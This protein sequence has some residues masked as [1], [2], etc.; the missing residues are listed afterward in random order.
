MTL[1][2]RQD[3]G[4]N[5]SSNDEANHVGSDES[6]LSHSHHSDNN[7]NHNH[8]NPQ[9]SFKPLQNNWVAFF[10]FRF[11]PFLLL[12][13][14]VVLL[15]DLAQ[16]NAPDPT[17][18]RGD[19][20]VFPVPAVPTTSSS[21]QLTTCHRRCTNQYRNIIALTNHGRAGLN[22][23]LYIINRLMQYAGYLCAKVYIPRPKFT[24]AP[25]HNSD[26]E[27]DANMP[28]SDF[29]TFTYYFT[30][31]ISTSSAAESALVDWFN[32]DNVE[33]RPDVARLFAQTRYRR[34]L[35]IKSYNPPNITAALKRLEQL[36][37]SSSSS[38]KNVGFVWQI[39]TS[40]Y[41]WE[42]RVA[43]F[44]WKRKQETTPAGIQHGHSFNITKKN[45]FVKKND[46]ATTFEAWRLM[47][48]ITRLPRKLNLKKSEFWGCKYATIDPT[49]HSKDMQDKIV[50]KVLDDYY[51]ENVTTIT[52]TTTAAA[53]TIQ[54]SAKN[55]STL[56][57]I[58]YF[59]I[60][61]GD[62]IGDCNTTLERLEKYLRRSFDS[63]YSFLKSSSSLSTTT[64]QQAQRQRDL[65]LLFSSDERD[66]QYRQGV[67]QLVYQQQQQVSR[68]SSSSSLRRQQ[69]PLP[70]V[71]FVD[72]DELT[73]SLIQEEI[74]Q[75]LAPA[76]R[77]NNFY[78][79]QLIFQLSYNKSV[80][81]VWLEQ[82]RGFGCPACTNMTEQLFRNHVYE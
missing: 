7:H 9:L 49:G 72:L 23:R 77:L 56:P 22:D 64:V 81:Q 70:R 3:H 33:E 58:G 68:S 25:N 78:L 42:D 43:E 61:R 75:G 74:R 13:A 54:S 26:T 24:L 66:V 27:V 67:A 32:E 30:D 8:T 62:A 29:G 53:S 17:N 60:R 41:D 44:L 19:S 12:Y 18:V 21:A 20:P 4:S 14:A 59:H 63:W 38:K 57:I 28:W 82:R 47:Q 39:N 50:R 69:P 36:V 79:Y 71:I 48:P 37:S 15:S 45:K 65:I 80:V 40:L 76:W 73:K 10:L 1:R 55:S 34:W 51:Q 31:D 16:S 2:Q 11:L 5:Q 35:H 6:S 52:R 46:D